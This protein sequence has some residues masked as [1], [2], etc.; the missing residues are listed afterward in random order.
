[1]F[2]T[3]SP[4]ACEEGERHDLFGRGLEG[5]GGHGRYGLPPEAFLGVSGAVCS[6]TSR[7]Q[8]DL[9]PQSRKSDTQERARSAACVTG[10]PGGLGGL[11]ERRSGVDHPSRERDRRLLY[12]A[13][14]GCVLCAGRRQVTQESRA[15]SPWMGFPPWWISLYLGAPRKGGSRGEHQGG[16]KQHDSTPPAAFFV[17]RRRHSFWGPVG[18]G[19][20]AGAACSAMGCPDKLVAPAHSAGASSLPGSR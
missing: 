7:S 1:M 10:F 6:A 15:A 3:F 9:A 8:T 18:R 5:G 11:A 16:G 13:G 4:T 2:V 19:C 17:R 14:A 12:S 20:L